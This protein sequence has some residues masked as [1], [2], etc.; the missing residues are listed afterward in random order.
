MPLP[1]LAFESG[2]EPAHKAAVVYTRRKMEG[3]QR[4]AFDGV[5]AGCRPRT[6]SLISHRREQVLAED[7]R[8]IERRLLNAQAPS[9]RMRS[10]AAN[11]TAQLLVGLLGVS[12]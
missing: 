11:D 6:R 12:D 8:L 10:V 2:G 1:E 7:V 3:E 5:G 4:E 9:N